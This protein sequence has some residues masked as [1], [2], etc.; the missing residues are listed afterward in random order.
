MT[1]STPARTYHVVH[2][3]RNGWEDTTHIKADRHSGGDGREDLC[4]MRGTDAV[5]F[6]E[7][8]RVVTWWFDENPS[9]IDFDLTNVTL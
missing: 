6:F 2:Q 8:S 3:Q 5:A 9:E 1:E 4:L 7:S